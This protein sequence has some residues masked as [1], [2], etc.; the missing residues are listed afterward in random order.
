MIRN[1]EKDNVNFDD[2]DEGKKHEKEKENQKIHLTLSGSHI[3]PVSSSEEK[4]TITKQ[5]ILI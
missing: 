4:K 3:E 1:K 2:H 5:V